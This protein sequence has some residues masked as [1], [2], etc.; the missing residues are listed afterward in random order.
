MPQGPLFGL[1]RLIA[2]RYDDAHSDTLP[3][4]VTYK[5]ASAARTARPAGTEKRLSLPA[6][7]GVAVTVDKDEAD[8]AW[9]ALTADGRRSAALPDGAAHRSAEGLARG[10]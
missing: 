6:V 1:D 8:Q 4:I 2:D 9:Q 10:Q 3:L 5:N 7:N